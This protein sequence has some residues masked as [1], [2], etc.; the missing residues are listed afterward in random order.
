M[1]QNRNKL[2]KLLI[3]NLSNSAV[4]RILEKSIT[5]KEE[6]SGKYRKEFL[7]SFEIAKRYREKINPINEKLSQKDISFIKDKIIK[8]VRVELLIRISKGYGNIDV[9]TIESEVDK[10]IKEIEFQDE[11]L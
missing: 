4:H 9:E 7:A 10:L 2:I 5:D 3:G 1:S 8:K 6:L 11:N